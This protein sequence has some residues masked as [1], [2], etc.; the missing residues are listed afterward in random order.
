[1]VTDRRINFLKKEKGG[2]QNFLCVEFAHA[3]PSSGR[4]MQLPRRMKYP[5]SLR[6][7]DQQR[8]WSSYTQITCIIYM[9]IFSPFTNTNIMSFYPFFV[10]LIVLL[11]LLLTTRKEEN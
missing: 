8:K 11:L 3:V 1:M 5:H 2:I 10:S 4:L 9:I 7:V 6:S